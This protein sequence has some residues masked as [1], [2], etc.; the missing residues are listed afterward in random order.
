MPEN[1]GSVFFF[2]SLLLPLLLVLLLSCIAICLLIDQLWN[3]D[4]YTWESWVA[5]PRQLVDGTLCARWAATRQD[6]R[7]SSNESLT[8]V[9]RVVYV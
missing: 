9:S 7:R 5:M 8:V 4:F 1:T 6:G 2:S 3:A